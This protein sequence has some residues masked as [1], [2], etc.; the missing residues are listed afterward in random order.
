[1][2]SRNDRTRQ[3]GTW[4]ARKPATRGKALQEPQPAPVETLTVRV[5]VDED[6]ATIPVYVNWAEVAHSRHDFLLQFLQLP[7]K[8]GPDT[9]ARIAETGELRVQPIVRVIM[10]PTLIRGLIKALEAQ[11]EKY[12]DRYGPVQTSDDV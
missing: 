6:D 12:Q 8:F 11:M 2:P 9:R 5:V 10:P 3:L 4:M 1:M 7:A